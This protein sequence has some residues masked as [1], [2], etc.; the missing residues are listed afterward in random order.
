[1]KFNCDKCG[2]HIGY[3]LDDCGKY[4]S[5]PHCNTPTI[6]P[7]APF[8]LP[9][10]L[11]LLAL[12]S[13]LISGGSYFYY[14]RQNVPSQREID[15]NKTIEEYADNCQSAMNLAQTATILRNMELTNYTS[16]DH[17]EES[18]KAKITADYWLN[19]AKTA[20]DNENDALISLHTYQQI[21]QDKL[22]PILSASKYSLGIA[23]G[24][25]IL[26]WLVK[27]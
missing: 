3:E 25:L 9:Q 26:S 7:Q 19:I 2:C 5:C 18:E 22:D 20:N 15:Q 23:F 4:G 14:N 6:V 11:I 21:R 17:Y 12:F 27:K 8:S 16:D 13:L 10:K 24:L 1:M